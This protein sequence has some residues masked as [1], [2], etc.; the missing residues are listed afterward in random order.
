MRS[1][2]A[3]T[4]NLLIDIGTTLRQLT[5]ARESLTPQL[6]RELVSLSDHFEQDLN[7]IRFAITSPKERQAKGNR[8]DV[9]G[10]GEGA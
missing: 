10:F 6:H 2:D 9:P 5:V 4:L 7:R 1:A 3:V 8:D